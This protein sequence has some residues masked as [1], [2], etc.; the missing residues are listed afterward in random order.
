[1]SVEKVRKGVALVFLCLIQFSAGGAQAADSPYSPAVAYD[2]VCTV[3]GDARCWSPAE[4]GEALERIFC[5]D[6][7]LDQP[8]LPHGLST[9][10]ASAIEEKP[11]QPVKAVAPQEPKLD[12]SGVPE[13]NAW[14]EGCDG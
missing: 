11:A 2:P 7:G 12:A 9:A 5:N 14:E 13:F 3:D 10:A 1:M 4:V 8:C 6:N